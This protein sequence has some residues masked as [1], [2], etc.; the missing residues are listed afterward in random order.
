MRSGVRWSSPRRWLLRVLFWGGAVAVG[1]AAVLFALASAQAHALFGRIL[2]VAPWFPLLG[3]PFACAAIVYLSQRFFPGSQGSGIPQTIAAL[4]EPERQDRE[5][6]LSLRIAI[7]KIGLTVFGLLSGA[8]VGREGPTVQ[9]GAAIMHALGRIGRFPHMAMDRALI[10]AGGAAGVAA[11]FNTPLAG[12]VFAIEELSRS[13]EQ[14]TNG[15]I[16]TAV[17]LSGVTSLA[18]LGDYTYFGRTAATVSADP[19][20]W[21]AVGA[22][23]VTGGL[24]GGLFARLLVAASNGIPGRV[25]RFASARPVAF[26]ALCGLVL[27]AIGLA[28]GDTTF[29]TGYLE[30]RSIL[31]GG[32][33]MPASFGLFK[34]LATLVSYL[35][36]IPGGIFAPSLAVGA[37]LGV[38]LAEIMPHI[39]TTAVVVLS[40]AAYFAGVVQAPLTAFVIVIEMT[41]KHDIVLLL[42]AVSLIANGTSRVIC[43]EPLYK[44]LARRFVSAAAVAPLPPPD[45]L[46][47]AAEADARPA[48]N[49]AD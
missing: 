39:P 21:L 40:M 18:I 2:L 46:E 6:L 38:N 31:Q 41:D 24:M 45:E 25:G 1:A 34:F 49:P 28:S 12:I 35:S 20:N 8:S 19:G 7:G 17:I 5:K 27:A 14:R 36:G 10:L 30:T 13:Y 47:D 11:A 22:I 29:G 3:M 23:G 37:G 16:L 42:M 26:A 48:P 9:V 32:G 33:E 15:T 4:G 43:P 44:A